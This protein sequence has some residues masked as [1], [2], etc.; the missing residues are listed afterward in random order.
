MRRV[1]AG[2]LVIAGVLAAM[3]SAIGPVSPA[4][5]LP[6]GF[7]TSMVIRNLM[8]P[9]NFE[10]APDGRVFV[11]ERAGVIKVFDSLDDPTPDIFADLRDRVFTNDG[12]GLLG[13]A[14]D[15]RWATKPYVYVL[16]AM[17]GPI[18]SAP[19]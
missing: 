17:D 7:Q 19:P 12:R 8:M 4:G 6:T 14:L 5:A 11:A 10:F 13:L 2:L 18:G 3:T 15:P 9:V 1:L 16:Y